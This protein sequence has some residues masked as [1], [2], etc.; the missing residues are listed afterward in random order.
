MDFQ[1]ENSGNAIM[2][3]NSKSFLRDQVAC[4]F[5]G[6]PRFEHVSPKSPFVVN[7]RARNPVRATKHTITLTCRGNRL[8]LLVCIPRLLF[9]CAPQ[10]CHPPLLPRRHA[11]RRVRPTA[12]SRAERAPDAVH[13]RWPRAPAARTT[14][15]SHQ[16][17]RSSGRGELARA[18]SLAQVS[19][20]LSRER[21]FVCCSAILRS[22]WVGRTL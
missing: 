6:G 9:V 12:R 11:R 1:L 3:E 8:L 20:A 7:G 18:Q 16:K 15:A 2:Y 5:N 10:V 19:R 22:G 17:K 4:C 14:N 13:R 21:G